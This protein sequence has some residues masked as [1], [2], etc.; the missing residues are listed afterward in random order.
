MATKPSPLST[1]AGRTKAKRAKWKAQYERNRAARSAVNAEFDG[2]V[3][4]Q[5]A[6]AYHSAI[7]ALSNGT[8]G[9]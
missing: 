2:E 5:R 1:C 3:P 7:K 6:G 4:L 9:S 8:Y